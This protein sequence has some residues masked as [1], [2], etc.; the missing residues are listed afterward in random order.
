MTAITMCKTFHEFRQYFMS[1]RKG[2]PV[3]PPVAANESNIPIRL[4]RVTETKYFD[5]PA[6]DFYF[7]PGNRKCP[8]SPSREST[9][10]QIMPG[11][12]LKHENIIQPRKRNAQGSISLWYKAPHSRELRL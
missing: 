1:D 11:A 3:T 12:S 5:R 9:N 7:T 4:G 10:G 8:L 6:S 2:G